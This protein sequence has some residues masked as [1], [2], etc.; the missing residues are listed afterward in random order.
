M[1]FTDLLADPAFT[2]TG[3]VK[4]FEVSPPPNV[5]VPDRLS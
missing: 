5:R 2:C 3:T 4:V 1:R